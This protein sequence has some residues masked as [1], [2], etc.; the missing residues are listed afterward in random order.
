VAY[1]Y[2]QDPSSGRY[3]TRKFR[4]EFLQRI[5]PESQHEATGG[6]TSVRRQPKYDSVLYIGGRFTAESA[7]TGHVVPFYLQETIGGSDI[8]GVPA[9]RGFQDYR[10]RAPNLFYLQAQYERRLLRARPAGEAP[11]TFRSIA[12][13]VGIMAFY[14]TGEVAARLSDLDMSNLRHS[15]GFGL[16]FWS[17]NKVWF[18]AYVGLGSGEGL[19]NFVGVTN[20]GA[21]QF[22]M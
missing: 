3:S 19:H 1:H 7:A 22:H 14:D 21:T 4:A 5:Y 9:L 10:F 20:P 8:E 12:S 17:G 11:S 2:Y 6:G 13:S 16:T 18:R 15:F